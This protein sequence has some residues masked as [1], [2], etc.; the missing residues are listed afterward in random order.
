MRLS[1]AWRMGIAVALP[2]AA[3]VVASVL[4]VAGSTQ[5]AAELDELRTMLVAAEPH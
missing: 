2:M 1:I 3:L 5:D 4:L